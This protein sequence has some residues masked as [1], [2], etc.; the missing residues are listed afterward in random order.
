MKRGPISNTEFEFEA[1]PT[2]AISTSECSLAS[3]NNCRK[4]HKYNFTS[5]YKSLSFLSVSYTNSSV[6]HVSCSTTC[7]SD[8]QV[9]EETPTDLPVVQL[10]FTFQESQQVHQDQSSKNLNE[11]LCGLLQNPQ[12]EK[13]AFEYYKKAR[14]NP[15]FR[16][17]R[18]MLRL[19]FRYLEQ[20]KNWDLILL[21]FKDLESY[22]VLP[23]AYTCSGLITSCI[24]ARKFRVL[25]G[26]LDVVQF[27][28]TI[29]ILAFDSAMKGYNKLH[30]FKCTIDVYDRM[31]SAGIFPNSEC[32]CQIMQ[33]CGKIGDSERVVQLF[34]ECQ[35]R[36]LETSPSVSRKMYKIL[37]DSLGKS[38]RAFEALE[39]FRD[40]TKKGIVGDSFVYSSLICSFARKREVKIAEELF[41]EAGE[42]RMLRD[43]E[44]FLKLVLMYIEDGLM[45][46][47]L[48]V[49]RAMRMANLKVSDCIF[50]TIVNG[51][52]KRRGFR[53]AIR[54]YEKLVSE[55][56]KP[57]QVTYASII[58]AHCQIGLYSEAEMLFSEMT[59]KGFDKCVVAY[60]SMVAMYGKTG[61]LNDAMK[62]VA[63]MKARGCQPNVWIYNSLM[64]MHGRAKNFRQVEKLWKEMK[65]RKVAPDKVSY[66]TIISAYNW[67]RE[68]DM[69]VRYY[70]EYRINGGTIDKAMA[71][72]MIGIFS[73]ISRIDELVKLLQDMRSEGTPLDGRLYWSASNALRDA[74]L[75]NQA[76]WLQENLGAR[77]T[78]RQVLC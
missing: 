66:T 32:Y 61:R 36:K 72:I 17:E 63:K 31:N 76:K 65:R 21:V 10:D 46:K 1:T 51:Y 37:I 58:N 45:E 52:S 5:V 55:G 41:R 27:D 29:A 48:E 25:Q 68:Y 73:K 50:C 42:K 16:P 60:S 67:S 78:S 3:I 39:Y 38:G 59:Q 77:V 23:D 40:M 9:L 13:L 49:A 56:F 18:S 74:G 22:H 44:L 26:L 4:P 69:C 11:T 62:L 28:S 43:P 8:H 33:A 75:E 2:M 35:S 15:E 6:L 70:Q 20:S 24:S 19:L 64:D 30:M 12:T 34:C 71:G 54:V 47:T 14:E 7:S 53:V 57:G